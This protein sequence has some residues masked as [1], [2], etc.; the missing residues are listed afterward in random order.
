MRR[1]LWIVGGGLALL[2]SPLLLWG[3]QV[4]WLAV[5]GQSYN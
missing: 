1:W 4:A 3:A 5:T 2:F